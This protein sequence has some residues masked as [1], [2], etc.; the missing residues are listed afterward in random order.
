MGDDSTTSDGGLDKT[1]KFFVTT[2]GEL[3][4]TWR[5]TFD[6]EILGGITSKFENFSSEVFHDG[7]G[8]DGCGGTDAS[9]FGLSEFQETMNSSDWELKSSTATA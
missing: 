7:S 4:V 1:V 2:D 9:S 5:N 3:Q 6:F 8:V